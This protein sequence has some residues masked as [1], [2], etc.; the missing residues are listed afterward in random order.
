MKILSKCTLFVTSMESG[1]KIDQITRQPLDNDK[2]SWKISSESLGT[3]F[4]EACVDALN[5]TL[6]FVLKPGSVLL[7]SLLYFSQSQPELGGLLISYL[8]SAALVFAGG[9]GIYTEAVFS[10]SDVVGVIIE[11]AYDKS[12]STGSLR[13]GYVGS[14]RDTICWSDLISGENVYLNM[15][16][17]LEFTRGNVNDQELLGVACY[18]SIS[19]EELIGEVEKLSARI[20]ERE[21]MEIMAEEPVAASLKTIKVQ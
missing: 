6:L 16:G 17:L 9:K 13:V 11:G 14:A 8:G 7:G 4:K 5:G 1:S 20:S 12:R 10:P 21:P 15:T 18:S 3:G 2:G 19:D